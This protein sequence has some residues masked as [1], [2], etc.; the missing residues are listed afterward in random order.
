[1]L[2]LQGQVILGITWWVVQQIPKGMGSVPTL[3]NFFHK[4]LLA[5]FVQCH[6]TYV[7]ESL[8]TESQIY[9]NI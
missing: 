1:M 2:L 5:Q 3:F 7:K 6:Y 9:T 8:Q 4:N